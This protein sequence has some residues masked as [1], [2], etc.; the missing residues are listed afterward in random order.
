MKLDILAIGAHPDDIELSCAATVAK[1]VRQGKK[2]GI[3]DLTEGE[4]GT[5]GSRSIRK[6]E[7]AAS[8]K[9]LGLSTRVSLGLKDGNI[10]VTQINIKKVIQLIRLFQPTILLIPHWLE[11]HP[12]H[13]HAHRLCR[14]AWFYSGLEKI[15]TKYQ[16]KLQD[17]YRPK[18]YFHFMQKYEFQPSFVVDVSDVYDVKK[19]SL[20]AFR[21]Q[22]YDPKSKERETIL[23]SRLFLES[24]YARD[25]HF[26]SLIN[27]EYG[28]PFF[29]VEPLGLNSFFDILV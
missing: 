15:V 21:S 18:K 9:I 22:F 17:P 24:I 20:L 5:R 19:E 13:E 3:L 11:R 29:S 4:L 2:V 7:A 25:R 8:G 10:E 28:E 6:N 26:G 12:D 23:S 27:V 1:L 16:G 14:E